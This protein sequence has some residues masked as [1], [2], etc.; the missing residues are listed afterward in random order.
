MSAIQEYNKAVTSLIREFSKKY[1]WNSD[2]DWHVIWEDLRMA[3]DV[4]EI[5]DMFWNIGNMYEALLHKIPRKKLFDWY[6]YCLTCDR[7]DWI[8][9]IHY[10]MGAK[11]YSEKDKKKDIKDIANKLESLQK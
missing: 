1:Y 4:I 5:S 2:M 3:P 10:Y 8:N 9:L 7:T 11:N 6:D